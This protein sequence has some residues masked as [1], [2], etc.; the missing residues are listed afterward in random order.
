MWVGHESRLQNYYQIKRSSKKKQKVASDKR[1]VGNTPIGSNQ[2]CGHPI[3]DAVKR[4]GN[5]S[6]ALHFFKS[7]HK[8]LGIPS[9]YEKLGRASF[10]GLVHTNVR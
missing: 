2:I 4:Y 6:Q 5:N 8:K 7:S 3:M 9:P 1:S 10:V